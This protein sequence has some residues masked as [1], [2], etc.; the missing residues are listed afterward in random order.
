MKIGFFGAGNMVS[1]LAKAFRQNSS[2]CEMY[3]YTPTKVNAIELANKLNGHVVN[4][5]IDMP[6]DLDWYFLGFKPQSLEDFEFNFKSQSKIIS[7]LAATNISILE[8]KFKNNKIARLMP[9]TPSRVYSGMNLVYFDKIFTSDEILN[10]KNLLQSCGEILVLQSE[11]QID[12]ITPFSGCGPGLIF[13]LAHIFEASLK[14]IVGDSIDTRKIIAQTFFGAS[15]LMLDENSSA[16]IELRDQVTS[17]KGV[18][19]EAL[20][21]LKLGKNNELYNRAFKAALARIHE[22]NRGDN[23]K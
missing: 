15:K 9:N 5:L 11:N 10:L 19:F 12:A 20:E 3:F 2:K 17:K 18:T 1:S 4:D 23:S 14:E 16:F 6:N 22:L 21:V 13:D 7:I 8:K